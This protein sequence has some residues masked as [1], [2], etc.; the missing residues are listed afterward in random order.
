MFKE[1]MW[2][3]PVKNETSYNLNDIPEPRAVFVMQEKTGSQR[4]SLNIILYSLLFI[5]LD[6]G[7]LLQTKEREL[8]GNL[9][10]LIDCGKELSTL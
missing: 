2:C 9:S 6:V 7:I 8:I 3:G 4:L 5:C 10:N 1:K